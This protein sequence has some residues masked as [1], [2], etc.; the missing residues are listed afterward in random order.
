MKYNVAIDGPSGAGKSVIALKVAHRFNLLHIDSGAMYRVI[1]LKA[2]QNDIAFDAE[3]K[4]VQLI[5]DTDIQMTR[6]R[7]IFMDGQDV[8]QLIRQEKISLGASDVSKLK[9]VRRLLV[10]AQQKLAQQKNCIMEGRDIGTVVLP[11]A[12]VKIFLTADVSV[13]AQRRHLDLLSK[14][15][16]SDLE[17]VKRDLILRDYQDTHRKESPLKQADDAIALD[18]THLSIEEV[19]DAIAEII[20]Q[21]TMKGEEC[22]D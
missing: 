17:Q 16:K 20:K 2:F 7:K 9:E 3:E 4:L 6:D 5:H 22:H 8:S 18:T 12:E 15:M 21:K 13:R 14:G 10:L 1:A 11:D 19:V